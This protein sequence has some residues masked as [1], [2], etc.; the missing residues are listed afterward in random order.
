[1]TQIT[2]TKSEALDLLEDEDAIVR[3]RIID[4]RRWTVTHEI[5]FHKEDK[6]YRLTYRVGATE[7]QDETPFDGKKEVTC[8][9]VQAVPSID[10][11][12]VGGSK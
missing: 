5:I 10:Y 1:M 8:Q 11:A 12:I 3:N 7:M 4:H 6:L 9:E 2:L